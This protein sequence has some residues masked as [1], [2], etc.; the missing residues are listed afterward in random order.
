MGPPLHF[1]LRPDWSF[2]FYSHSSTP[3]IIIHIYKNDIKFNG[4]CFFEYLNCFPSI[5]YAFSHLQVPSF[6]S[7]IQQL[8]IIQLIIFCNFR[9][10]SSPLWIFL[11]VTFF[12]FLMFIRIQVY[13]MGPGAMRCRVLFHTFKG[14]RSI[15]FFCCCSGDNTS[16]LPSQIRA[17]Q[18]F[19]SS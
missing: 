10:Y 1:S 15:L 11:S 7:K 8:P 17:P 19:G 4:S 13:L 3:Y 14:D 16:N 12:C 9:R 6:W 5:P 2:M 18:F